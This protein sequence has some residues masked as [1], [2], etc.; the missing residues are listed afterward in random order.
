MPTNS[1]SEGLIFQFSGGMPPAPLDLVLFTKF[2]LLNCF[3][4]CMLSW[5]CRS[6]KPSKVPSNSILEGLIF[7][8][9]LG[10]MNALH[11]KMCIMVHYNISVPP[12]VNPGSP[13]DVQLAI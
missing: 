9:F 11:A 13:M 7:Q 2:T 10:G 12:F 4:M 5:N 1:I 3:A 6:N 8:D